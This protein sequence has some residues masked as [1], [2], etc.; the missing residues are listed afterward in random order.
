M[1]NPQIFTSFNELLAR[2][3]AES[4]PNSTAHEQSGSDTPLINI[5]ISMIDLSMI[6]LAGI[7]GALIPGFST[8]TIQLAKI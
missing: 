8:G 1:S 3:N 5:D 6:D 7:G 4:T 2:N